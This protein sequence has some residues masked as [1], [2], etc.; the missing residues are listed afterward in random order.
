MDTELERI[1][2]DDYLADLSG[3]SLA[4]L[5]T[6]RGEC[7]EIE[8]ELSYL[9][10][11]VQGRIDI[12]GG[13]LHRRRSGG[14]PNDLSALIERLPEILSDRTRS[15][16]SGHLPQVMAPG[17]VTGELV[18]EIAGIDVDS[19]LTALSSVPDDELAVTLQRL[20]AVE[21]KVSG[22]RKELFGRID[23]IQTELAHRY[24]T[25]EATVDALLSGD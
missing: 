1:L 19:H 12:V 20:E 10:R 13:E 6:L 4:E 5:R 21:G 7:Q 16:G 24:Q 25:G 8:T 18:E 15:S 3:R 11:L 9:R 22:L 2:S 17:K 14:D 23:T